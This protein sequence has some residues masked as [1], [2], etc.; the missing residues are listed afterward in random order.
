MTLQLLDGMMVKQF[1]SRRWQRRPLL[2]RKAIPA[3][4]ESSKRLNCFD[5]PA[6][7]RWNRGG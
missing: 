1:L 5:S 3:L 6:A 2:V 7:T 4:R